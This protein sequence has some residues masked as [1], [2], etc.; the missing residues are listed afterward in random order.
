MKDICIIIK[1]YDNKYE[2]VSAG[3]DV[4]VLVKSTGYTLDALM[5]DTGVIIKSDSGLMQWAL[6]L[7]I[8]HADN[9]ENILENEDIMSI[10]E[11]TNTIEGEGGDIFNIDIM[12]LFNRLEESAEKTEWIKALGIDTYTE[13][14]DLFNIDNMIV[15]KAK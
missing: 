4:D 13:F 15:N 10:F 3:F 8:V 14:D 7:A 12:K 6:K 11:F 9:Y 5:S 2:I 1:E